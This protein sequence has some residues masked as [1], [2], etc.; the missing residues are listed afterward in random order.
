MNFAAQAR[1]LL[2]VAEAPSPGWADELLVGACLGGD[3]RAWNAVIDKYKRLIYSVAYRYHA[4]PEDAAD[5]FQAVCIELFST[6]DRLREPAA[7]RGWLV[8]VTAHNALRWRRRQARR[9]D[10]ERPG[11]D[12]AALSGGGP[13]VDDERQAL[14]R[15]QELRESV[16]RLP[17]RCQS[18]I[19]MLFFDD[20]P[21]PYAEVAASLGLATGSIGF[22]RGRCLDKLKKLMTEHTDRAGKRA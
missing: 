7:L 6:L 20:P 4:T 11:D 10:V 14:E 17:D 12:V 9:D 16:M 19:R 3:E 5:I 1:S 21:R 18:M 15:A 13:T 8:T 2:P 22:I